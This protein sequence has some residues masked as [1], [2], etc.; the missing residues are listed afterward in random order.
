MSRVDGTL[1]V[2]GRPV[3]P[4][5]RA[6]SYFSRARGLLGTRS[7]PGA[8]LITPGNSVHGLGML[9]R[10]DVALL[11]ADLLVLHTLSLRPFGLTRPRFGVKHVLEAAF[12]AF[13]AWDLHPGSQLSLAP[14]D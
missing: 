3:G 11:D 7:V 6:D 8:L 5:R 4:L 13:T 10:L 2:D 14:P 9:Y 12:G 1:L